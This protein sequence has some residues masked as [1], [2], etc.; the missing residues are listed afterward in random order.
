MAAIVSKTPITILPNYTAV[1][2]AME[3]IVDEYDWVVDHD[4][5]LWAEDLDGLWLHPMS[6]LTGWLLG[7]NPFLCPARPY[8]NLLGVEKDS[9]RRVFDAIDNTGTEHGVRLLK[10][11]F[12]KGFTH[13]V[14]ENGIRYQPEGAT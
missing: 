1:V 10:D 6:A 4:M 7:M 14:D 11:I 9:I 8:A 5:T 2:S 12:P 3:L 13:T